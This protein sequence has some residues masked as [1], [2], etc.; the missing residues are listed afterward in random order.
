MPFSNRSFSLTEPG[1]WNFKRLGIVFGVA[2]VLQA[3]FLPCLCEAGAAKMRLAL[4][5][6]LLVV[7]RLA[8]AYLVGE[9]GSGRKFYA[10]LLGTSPVWVNVVAFLIFGET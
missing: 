5:V 3:L 1:H 2:I 9:K 6:D 4:A 10:W 8:M 7:I